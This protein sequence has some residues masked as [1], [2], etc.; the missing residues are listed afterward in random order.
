MVTE[1]TVA[2][3]ESEKGI[4]SESAAGN[5]DLGMVLFPGKLR[6]FNTSQSWYPRK[7]MVSKSYDNNFEGWLVGCIGYR[8]QVGQFYHTGF[9]YWLFQKSTERPVQIPPDQRTP[10]TGD[11]VSYTGSV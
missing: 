4:C 7:Q 2:I 8:D 9:A 3:H 6:T 10:V 11:W 5:R 1:D